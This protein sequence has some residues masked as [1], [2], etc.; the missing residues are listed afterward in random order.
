MVTPPLVKLG[1]TETTWETGNSGE[2]RGGGGGESRDLVFPGLG[3][4]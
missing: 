3:K 4:P 2:V 1:L